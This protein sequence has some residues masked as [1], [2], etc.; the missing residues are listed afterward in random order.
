[1]KP[2]ILP[3][4]R[5]VRAGTLFSPAADVV[6]GACL[7]GL[8]LA[9]G[10]LPLA[11]ASVST[12][13]GGMVLNDFA[14][15]AADATAR[16]E[17]PIPRGEVKPWAALA[18]GIGLLGAAALLSPATWYHGALAVLVLVYDFLAKRNLLAGAVTMG[19]LRAMNL[20][21]PLAL[22]DAVPEVERYRFLVAASAYFVY[23]LA[24]TVLGHLEDEPRVRARAV[25]A[26]QAA[27][28]VAAL[29]AL[30]AVQGALWP[31]PALAM[32]AVLAFSGR[33]RRIAVWDQR[34]IRGSMTWLLLGTMLYTSL[35]CVAVG[36]YLAGLAVA[37]AILPARRISRTIA[38]T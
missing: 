24:V 12:Y 5:L 13:A 6:A 30:V 18:L 23:I 10:V 37:A 3:W 34:A 2:V 17:R 28:P 9:S 1:L 11:L 15:R 38:L 4:L 33:N 32:V 26:L 14:D 16:R 8:G 27:P 7:G 29:A 31:A 20:C 36:S 21:A 35:L 19:T 22:L 25:Q